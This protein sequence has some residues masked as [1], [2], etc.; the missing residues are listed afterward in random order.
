VLGDLL[1]EAL[2]GAV[3][4][5]G[6]DFGNIQLV[7]PRTN[8]LRIVCQRGFDRE[9]LD[10]FAVV[11]GGEAACGRAAAARRQAVIADVNVDPAFAPHRAIAAASGFRAVQSTPL[12]DQTGRLH[13]VLSTHFRGV[14]RPPAQE[15]RMTVTFARIV[16]RAI[17]R[18]RS[19][20]TT[21]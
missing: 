8:A 5:L 14:H 6:A 15:L 4:F 10:H 1:D 7:D 20:L 18:Q 9:F 3:A 13:G 17:A 21:A 2:D 16:A 12:I 11:G 19:S